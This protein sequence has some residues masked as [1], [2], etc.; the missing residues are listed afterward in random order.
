MKYVDEF[1]D[2]EKAQ[3]L[4]K[5]IRALVPQIQYARDGN[6]PIYIMEVC[7]GHTHAIF[8]YG[9]E[10]MLPDGI[11]LIHGPGCPVC[12]LPMGRVDDCVALAHMPGMIFT[13]FGDAMRVPGSKESLL[14]ANANGADVRMVYS[15]LDSLRIAKENPDREVCFFALGFETTMP[16]TA[17]TVLRAKKE[18]IKNFT[19]FCNH[20]TI[21]PTIKAILDSP[22]LQLDGFL[23][24][25]HVSMVIG[26]SP[27]EF[28]A[29]VYRRPVVIAG[30]EPLDILQSLWMVLKQLAE[31]RV[32][33]E[34]QYGRIVP[35][36]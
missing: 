30:F 17:L 21:I 2:P 3:F 11:E 18:G 12:V 8:R 24:P 20:I 34:N 36:D 14:Q 1:R 22:D 27:Y 29:E 16:S 6:D 5:E 26:T 10:T 31:K 4:L 9:V 19:L 32:A 15:P 33:I 25:G 35:R 28:I 13:T 7:G 23:G